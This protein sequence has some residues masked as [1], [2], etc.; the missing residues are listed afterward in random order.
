MCYRSRRQCVQCTI[1]YDNIRFNFFFSAIAFSLWPV[2]AEKI[3]TDMCVPSFTRLCIIIYNTDNCR[4]SIR[5]RSEKPQKVWRC[6]TI[7]SRRNTT[8]P[9]VESISDGFGVNRDAPTRRLG[10]WQFSRIESARGGV[11]KKKKIRNKQKKWRKKK[12]PP[13]LMPSSKRSGTPPPGIR[14]GVRSLWGNSCDGGGREINLTYY[15]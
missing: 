2:N 6:Y 15:L 9:S 14:R 10:K 8:S 4:I 13:W 3:F 7:I 11:G 5:K 1:R 12:N